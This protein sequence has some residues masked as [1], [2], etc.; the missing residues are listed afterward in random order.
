VAHYQFGV[1]IADPLQ[2]V[3]LAGQ[4]DEGPGAISPVLKT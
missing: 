1:A 3:D 2:Y 4:E